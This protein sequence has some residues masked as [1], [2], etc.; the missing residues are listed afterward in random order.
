[1]DFHVS[2]MNFENRTD[3]TSGSALSSMSSETGS[4]GLQRFLLDFHSDTREA[5]DLA[6]GGAAEETRSWGGAGWG[7]SLKHWD[8]ATRTVLGSQSR[9]TCPSKTGRTDKLNY[10]P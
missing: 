9:S 4:C 1:M 8:V 2:T 3:K 6:W 5:Q 10:L 7:Q